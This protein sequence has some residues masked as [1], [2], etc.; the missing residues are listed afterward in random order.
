VELLFVVLNY[1]T[2][3]PV[4]LIV[5]GFSLYQFYCILGNT[6]TIEGW[7][8]D[9]VA[10]LIR[11]GKIRRIK[12]PYNIGARR[13]IESMLGTNPLLWCCPNVGPFGTGLKYQ[14]AEGDGKW[15][16]LSARDPRGPEH[17]ERSYGYV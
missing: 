10:T 17:H 9:K 8:K 1:V 16:E 5:G 2:C 12:F 6:T 7:E 14:L 15:I 11:R 3:V 13:N 4:L